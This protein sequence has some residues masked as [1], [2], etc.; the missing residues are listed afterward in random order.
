MTSGLFSPLAF[1]HGPAM[2][3]RFMLA[4]LTNLQSNEDGTISEDELHWLSMRAKGGFGL[5]MSCAAH[6]Q[7]GGKGF[8]GQLGIFSDIHLPGL[9]RL[10]AAINATG[11]LSAVQLQHSG[12]RALPAFIEGPPRAPWDDPETGATALST[13]EVEQL[14]EDFILAGL[15]AEKA[16]F[17]GI[18]LHAAHSYLLCLFMN[19]KNLREDKFGGS[20]ENRTRVLLSVVNGLRARTQPEFQIGVRISPERHGM[21]LPEV[22]A[23]VAQ[24]LLGGAVDYI[25]LSM[26]DVFKLPHDKA[27]QEKPLLAYFTDLPRGQTRLGVAGK[28]YTA[29]GARACME[30]GLDFVLIGRGA[31]LHHDFPRRVAADP[32]FEQVQ[33]PVTAAYLRNE[34][35]GPAFISY[36]RDG[37]KNF[38]AG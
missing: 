13:G 24:L 12:N 8:S 6:V 1:A 5:T 20:F 23:L 26:W 38:V 19:E 15:R 35:L 11:S 4:P 30:A 29:A 2:A 16:G 17:N 36:M 28:I 18:E 37:W 7:A 32:G 3:N 33:L 25:D 22:R 9:T 10:A 27:Y 31:I 14:I 21:N 34:G